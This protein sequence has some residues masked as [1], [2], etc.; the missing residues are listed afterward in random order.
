MRAW[1]VMFCVGL[2]IALVWLGTI[3]ERKLESACAAKG[4]VLVESRGENVC[5]KELR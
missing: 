5:V 2:G 3:E 1:I 4:G